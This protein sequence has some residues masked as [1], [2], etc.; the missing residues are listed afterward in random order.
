MSTLELDRAGDEGAGAVGAGRSASGVPDCVG[1]GER[2]A[3]L[4]LQ[5]RPGR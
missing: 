2:L 3:V 1:G 5:L 4:A